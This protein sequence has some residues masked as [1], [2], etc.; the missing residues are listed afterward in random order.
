MI[1]I[2]KKA[3]FLSYIIFNQRIYLRNFF[4]YYQNLVKAK[5]SIKNLNNY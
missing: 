4:F 5:I 3:Y 1:F 2:K